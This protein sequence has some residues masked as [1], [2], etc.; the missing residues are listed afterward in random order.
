MA[1][2]VEQIITDAG[3]GTDNILVQ[4]LKVTVL[5]SSVVSDTVLTHK[6]FKICEGGYRY[7][8]YFKYDRLRRSYLNDK[9]LCI[10][11]L[12]YDS[13]LYCL[14]R[15]GVII[16]K[17]YIV[18]GG[19]SSIVID[20]FGN[21]YVGSHDHNIYSFDKNGNLRWKILT[22]NWVD[23][24]PALYNSIIYVGNQSGY[25]YAINING[26]ILWKYKTG[27]YVFSSPVIHYNHYIIFGCG[28]GGVYT[29]D[30]G[31]SLKWKFV[32]GDSVDSSP[33]LDSYGNIYFGSYD[34]YVYSITDN[35]SLRW[36]YMTWDWVDT[37]PAVYNNAVYIASWDYNVYALDLNGNLL[38]TFE[39]GD[40]ITNSS[41][42]I[43]PSGY[44]IVGSDDRN[45]YAI[46]L[47][48][49]LKW[50][51]LTNDCVENTS[52]IDN[53]ELITISDYSVYLYG[54][55]EEG[56]LVFKVNIGYGS[57]AGITYGTLDIKVC[58]TVLTDKTLLV[59]EISGV[60]E[61]ILTD[62]TLILMDNGIFTDVP[63][64][65]KELILFDTV[66]GL[67]TPLVYKVLSLTDYGSSIDVTLTHKSLIVP[68]VGNGLDKLLI[69]KHLILK[70]FPSVSELI[71]VFGSGWLLREA[72]RKTVE[73]MKVYDDLYD[74]HYPYA[75]ADYY[76][77]RFVVI[78]K[79]AI[80]EIIR[81][82]E[83]YFEYRAKTILSA[84]L[85]KA[86][87]LVVVNP[88]LYDP[89]AS[90][91]DKAFYYA[92]YGL[93]IVTNLTTYGM[94]YRQKLLTFGLG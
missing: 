19:Y 1:T 82:Y 52:A 33:A 68:D 59:S 51:Y 12:S 3:L 54:F 74:P 28:D 73:L 50:K 29:L 34:T 61:I 84:K 91:V 45:V 67:D 35:G 10:Y 71:D 27:G 70:E 60:S 37:T 87:Q 31:G 15:N 2:P 58:E 53:T 42:A 22:E 66:A 85:S 26:N 9:A 64:V 23:S 62:K 75:K 41:P 21:C 92:K 39:T 18:H 79:K 90:E 88:K 4:K 13:Y 5:D 7:W 17:A 25:V 83:P 72:I 8:Q 43:S 78:S 81:Q 49:T 11:V 56:M 57:V 24:T 6:S 93:R 32:A 30:F 69:N 44:L 47:D 38:W 76:R 48:G 46:N 94:G 20:N 89:L 40:I 14:D 16:W 77:N 63:L 55:N 80:R 86:L 65:H 36:K